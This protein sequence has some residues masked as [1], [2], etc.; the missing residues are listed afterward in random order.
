M[1]R[2]RNGPMKP[3]LYNL[4]MILVFFIIYLLLRK[5]IGANKPAKDGKDTEP[6][7]IDI[8]NLAVT[9]QTSVGVP[10][11]YPITPL[12]KS[13]TIIQQILLIFGNLFIIHFMI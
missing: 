7:I 8:F 2:K 6:S 9:I 10:L 4:F 13:V 1:K 12:A 3:I 5:Q 11:V